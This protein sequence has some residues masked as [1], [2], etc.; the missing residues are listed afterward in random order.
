MMPKIVNTRSA[1]DLDKKVGNR[2]RAYRIEAGMSQEELGSKLGVSFQQI[3]KYEKG[4]NRLAVVRMVEVCKL[5]KITPHALIDWDGAGVKL[6]I[7]VSL[8][9]FKLAEAFD[10][11]PENVKPTFRRLME[12]ISK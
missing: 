7:P 2:L 8:N 11:L 10:G 4:S 1:R 9:N 12:L 3:Q 6:A 5:L